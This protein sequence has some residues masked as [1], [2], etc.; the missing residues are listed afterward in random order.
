MCFPSTLCK[1]KYK[2]SISASKTPYSNHRT[3]FPINIPLN[4][5]KDLGVLR[6]LKQLKGLLQVALQDDSVKLKLVKL[7]VNLVCV[8]CVIE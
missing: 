4:I 3:I 8:P 2:E 1:H 7:L 5:V 6:V